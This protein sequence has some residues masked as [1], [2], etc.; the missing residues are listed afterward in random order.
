MY[1]KDNK[2]IYFRSKRLGINSDVIDIPFE[3][4]ISENDLETKNTRVFSLRTKDPLNTT[5]IAATSYINGVET[6]AITQT[7]VSNVTTES[8]IPFLIGAGATDGP[9]YEMYQ[10]YFGELIIFNTYHDLTTHN[11]IIDFLKNRWGIN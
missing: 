8:S 7:N 6:T 10:G 4:N 5:S 3:I 9:S 11:S 1:V 2:D